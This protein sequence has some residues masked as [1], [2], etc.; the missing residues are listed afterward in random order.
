MKDTMTNE[1]KSNELVARAKKQLCEDMEDRG[2]GAILWDNGTA[3]FHYIPEIVE[4]KDK[5]GNDIVTRVTGL[6]DCDGRLYAIEE[7][8]PYSHLTNYYDASV[9]AAPTVVTL[10]KDMAA[11]EFGDAAGKKGFTTA[12]TNAEWLAIADCYFEAL[13]E[14]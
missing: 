12:G 14:K 11:S 9:D 2:I 5:E 1:A 3:G 6:Y 4:G 10:T 13:N 7:G 8:A